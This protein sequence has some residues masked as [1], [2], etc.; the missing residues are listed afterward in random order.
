MSDTARCSACGVEL[1]HDATPEGLCAAC[2]LKLGLSSTNLRVDDIPPSMPKQDE[3]VQSARRSRWRWK[4]PL[5]L[6]G[7]LLVLIAFVFM[8]VQRRQPSSTEL[9]VLRFRLFVP[10]PIEF[11]VSPDGRRVAFTAM[12]DDGKTLLWV[13]PLDSFQD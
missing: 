7:A 13:H 12:N 2:L 4:G 8:F 9:G 1:T 5:I 3:T 10:N 6:S 11:A